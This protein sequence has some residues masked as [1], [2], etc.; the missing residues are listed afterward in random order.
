MTPTAL[1]DTKNPG[2]GRDQH[3]TPD[4]P[5]TPPRLRSPRER[6]VRASAALWRVVDRGE[7]VLGHLRA[8][9]TPQGTRYRAERY[10][11]ASDRMIE[12]GAF[13][14]ADDAVAV[15]R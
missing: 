15:L 9:E 10:H 4:V 8:L 11:R 7:R 13:W 12:V 6:L 2:A 5:H 14:S 1:Y 3:R